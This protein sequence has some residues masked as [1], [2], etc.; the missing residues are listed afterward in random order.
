MNGFCYLQIVNR[1]RKEMIFKEY[2][3]EVRGESGFYR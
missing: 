1:G 3:V 2:T